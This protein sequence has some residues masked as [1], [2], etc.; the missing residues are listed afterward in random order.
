MFANKLEATV[1]Q[2][3]YDRARQSKI[4]KPND[5]I[6]RYAVSCFMNQLVTQERGIPFCSI[7]G[8]SC[9]VVLFMFSSLCLRI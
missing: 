2:K 7:A 8:D 5:E 9:A 6:L 4:D 3:L 1:L